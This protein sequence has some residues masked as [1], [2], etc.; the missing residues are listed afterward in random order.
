M[1][2]LYKFFVFFKHYKYLFIV[3]YM[4]VT[5]TYELSHFLGQIIG[6]FGK[7]TF[8]LWKTENFKG[9]Y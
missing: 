6:T 3:Y 1:Y 8:L 2:T 9:I 7:M 4:S 5:F